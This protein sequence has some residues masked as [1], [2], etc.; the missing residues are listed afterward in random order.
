MKNYKFALLLPFVAFS[1]IGCDFRDSSNSPI[2]YTKVRYI[3][4]STYEVYGDD[5]FT[6]QTTYKYENNDRLVTTEIRRISSKSVQCDVLLFRMVEEYDEFYR[7]VKYT[8]EDYIS[9]S[10]KIVDTY[11]Y[12]SLGQKIMCLTEEQVEDNP[13]RV[14]EK[15]T[16]DY[17]LNGNLSLINIFN[18]SDELREKYEYS[19]ISNMKTES[20]YDYD[21]SNEIPYKKYETIT[22][23]DQT[24]N[25]KIVT[26]KWK[27]YYGEDCDVVDK[28]YKYNDSN[29]LVSYEESELKYTYEY[30][31]NG[32]VTVEKKYRR[33]DFDK[34]PE[35][36]SEIISTY[37]E[38]SFITQ[39]C[40]FNYNNSVKNETPSLKYVFETSEDGCVTSYSEYRNGSLT[41][42]Y[43][44]F[45]ELSEQRNR[46]NNLLFDYEA[47]AK[48]G[49][50]K[51][52]IND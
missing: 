1:I 43:T 26:G 49:Y 21:Y 17:D 51:L 44:T 20:Y 11:T 33:E 18:S 25:L 5:A 40:I 41:K 42:E 31:Q 48:G 2:V 12:N 46:V 24:L 23:Y 47:I 10:Y 28:I 38:N 45:Y 14:V 30:N 37:N 36:R 39:Q 16:Y 22:S 27:I 52:L 29:K 50:N 9:G 7:L 35:I 32:D 19:Y 8:D 3:N 34:T 4:K 6:N 15:I 13:F